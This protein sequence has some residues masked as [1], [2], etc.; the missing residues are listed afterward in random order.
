MRTDRVLVLYLLLAACGDGP[1]AA[2]QEGAGGRRYGGVFNVNEADEPAGIFPLEIVHA[3]P[4]RMAA[5][6]YEGLVRLGQ[7]QLA[8]EPALAESWEVDSTGLVYTFHLRPQ[9]FFHDDPCFRNGVGREFNADDVVACFKAI[10][11]P[12][13]GDPMFWLLQDRIAGAQ[14][15]HAAMARGEANAPLRGV[16]R[17]DDRTVRITLASPRADL[18]Q[19]LTHPG[20][21]IYPQEMVTT[22]G[23]KASWHPVG[24]GPFRFRVI[25]PGEAMVLE[26]NPR[27]WDHD[28]FGNQLPFLDAVRY[29]FIKDRAQEVREFAQGRLTMVFDPPADQR[30]PPQVRNGAAQTLARP[31]L[32]VQYYAFNSAHPP[33]KDIRIREAFVM[34][35]DRK[36]IVDSLLP[37]RGEPAMHGLVPPGFPAYPYDSIA[38]FVHD[39]DKARALLADAGFPAGAGLPTVFMQVSNNG[40]GYVDMAGMIQNMLERELG[41]RVVITVL[42]I[43]QHYARV[44]RGQASFWREGWVADHP[45]PANFLEMFLGRHVPADTVTPSY[46]NSTRFQDPEFD[47]IMDQVMRETDERRRM[48]ATARAE[49][50]L[51]DQY[52]VIPLY[53]EHQ[54]RWLQPWVM[55]MHEN[56]MG[57]LELARVWFAPEHRS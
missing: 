24:T 16:E 29:T 12:G 20:C 32:S 57:H 3:A 48:G 28:E 14:A 1:G 26:R 43:D 56:G 25:I 53:Y 7:G 27:Y 13:V 2:H 19:V 40:Y 54:V 10:C 11:T 55:G 44:E 39:P 45:S 23:R 37:G 35:I 38:S 9:V 41:V 17:L 30:E 50:R 46:L 52:V 47:R 8:V 34:A 6:M 5:H 51:L 49:Q 33:F 18:L 31:G 22:Y 42:P 21:A 36:A 4:Q 15:F